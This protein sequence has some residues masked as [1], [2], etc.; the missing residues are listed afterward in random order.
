MK[1]KI[2]P[3]LICIVVLFNY[4]C[5]KDFLDL[6]PNDQYTESALWTSAGDA[7]AALSGCYTDW[8]NGWW[9]YYVDCASDNA[10]NPYPWEGFT[11]LGNG[12]L[13]TPNNPGDNK[14][15]FT[16]IQRCNWFLA[17]IEKTPMDENLKKRMKAE[18]RFLRAYR[19]F[20]M[21]QLYGDVPLMTT[22]ITTE[23]ANSVAR[24]PKAEVLKFVLDE[25]SEISSD[26]PESYSGSDVGRITKGA[27]IALKAR[28]E[29]FN[30]K[31]ADCISS[32][33][34]ILGRY[35]LYNSYSDLFRPQN[36]NNSEIILDVQNVET[37]DLTAGWQKD[38]GVMMIQTLGGWWSVD[39]SQSLVDTY[40]MKNGKTIDDRSSGYDPENPLKNRDPRL[41]AT[42]IGPGSL[43]EGK[44][45]DPIGDP[46]SLDFY[47]PYY[48]TGYADKKYVSQVSDFKDIWHTGIN[49]PIIRYAEVLLNY[50][51]AKI[52]LN[53]IDNSVYSAI[54]EIRLRAGMPEVDKVIYNN[55]TKMRELVRRE[56]RVELAMEGL[57]WF[58][59]QRW[60]IGKEVMNGPLYGCRLG[61]VDPHTGKPTFT[62]E[63]I[64]S[65]HRVFNESINYLWP[66]PQSDID[67]NKNLTQNP[68]Y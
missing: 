24:N 41:D 8:E 38:A 56:R 28:T 32:C 20:L 14:W 31:Y 65:E 27:A 5:S 49:I 6:Q 68:G 7:Q 60:K 9:V 12:L 54:N 33:N 39:P 3:I 55:Q 52:E 37:L 2:I 64:V 61:T 66:I 59:I 10:F 18:A 15:K 11:M 43:V 35:S 45:F 34:A 21:S 1:N 25:L 48:Y 46:S 50:A 30:E 51:E 58:D 17:G 22:N 53:Q 57:R 63:R 42:I 44:Y 29:L 62:S 4:S 16:T 26:L 23:L 67:I 47:G 19:Y 36:E 13:L 40:E